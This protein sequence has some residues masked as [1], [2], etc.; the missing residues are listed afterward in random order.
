[1]NKQKEKETP[2]DDFINGIFFVVI[3]I[4]IFVCMQFFV[5][6]GSSFGTFTVLLGAAYMLRGSIDMAKDKWKTAQKL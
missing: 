3:G 6:E 2:L 1:M 5:G 4:V